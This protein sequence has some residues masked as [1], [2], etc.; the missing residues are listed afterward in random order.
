V[1]VYS[2]PDFLTSHI[3]LLFKTRPILAGKMTTGENFRA[4]GNIEAIRILC[5]IAP[6]TVILR[7]FF[8]TG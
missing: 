8:F 3:F 6:A 7:L 1:T 5:P 4:T 2:I